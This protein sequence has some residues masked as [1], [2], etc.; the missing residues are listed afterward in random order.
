MFPRHVAV[1][2]G[3]LIQAT[4]VFLLVA[5]SLAPATV[6]R[7]AETS[8]RVA[9]DPDDPIGQGAE[10]MFSNGIATFA[11]QR[12]GAM[13][14]VVVDPFGP[15][16]VWTLE[17]EAAGGAP[18]NTGL[19]PNATGVPA[20]ASAPGMQ[21]RTDTRGCS[22]VEGNFDVRQ[23]EVDLFGNV[24]AMRVLFEQHCDGQAPALRGEICLDA[25]VPLRVEAP[26]VIRAHR[27]EEAFLFVFMMDELWRTGT[28]AVS[29]QPAP[30]VFTDNGDNTATLS[31]FTTLDDVGRTS[32]TVTGQVAG[33]TETVPVLIDVTG[34]HRLVLRGEAGDPMLN[35]TGFDRNMN[36]GWF[37]AVEE[38]GGFE[39]TFLDWYGDSWSVRM[40]NN[41]A[42]P[43]VEG[44]DGAT[45]GFGPALEIRHNGVPAADGPGRVSVRE[46]RH[47]GDGYL[48]SIRA[49][50]EVRPNGGPALRGEVSINSRVFVSLRSPMGFDMTAG[51]SVAFDVV[52]DDVRGGVPALT[53]TGLPAGATFADNRNGTG[54]FAWTSPSGVSSQHDVIITATGAGGRFDRSTTHLSVIRPNNAPIAEAN[55]P[56]AGETGVAVTLSS[57][58]S[59]DPDQDV[60]GYL[61]DFG[62][63]QTSNAASPSHAWATPGTY[64]IHLRVGDGQAT[65]MDSAVAVVT[66]PPPTNL[67]ARA[68]L[69]GGNKD[70]K[71]FANRPWFS[72]QMERTDRAFQAGE[73]DAASLV[74]I[75]TGTGSIDRVPVTASRTV[76]MEDTDDNAR[77]E[78]AATFDSEQLKR[79]FDKFTRS[80]LVPVTIEGRLADGRTVT[81]EV[82]LS[83]TTKPGPPVKTKDLGSTVG[84]IVEQ[85][86]A[87]RLAVRL[88]DTAGRLVRE[89][90]NA[91]RP[92]GVHEFDLSSEGR[93]PAG[94][95]FYRVS[96]D[97]QVSGG[98]LM[99]RP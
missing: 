62:D 21:I 36:D 95:Y 8:F 4:L 72:V 47:D 15:G 46:L 1:R 14:Q 70:F 24:T 32:M 82:T 87:G 6:A 10:F 86:T 34:D 16:D 84:L 61:W 40:A 43:L 99:I 44:F 11:C 26:R 97:G 88:F 45:G 13:V 63:G 81:A 25:D 22:Y 66:D 29:G 59:S 83:V 38:K 17:F 19:Y 75:S 48:E 30:S 18:L 74:M 79:L 94:L 98:K 37:W 85:T 67:T 20:A 78:L 39:A 35:G 57:A 31:W 68:F 41:S 89:V 69:T 2:I 91:D 52:A 55:G 80:T 96:V 50:F 49:A 54:H 93:L 90:V 27:G 71:T 7:A 60:L 76:M 12:L 9:S 64:T 23:F 92:A 5:G 53:A 77:V 73:V 65:A 51:E 56:Y 28:V 33:N 3:P 42:T 58:G